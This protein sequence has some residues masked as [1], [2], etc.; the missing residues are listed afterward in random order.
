MDPDNLEVS[1]NHLLGTG[2]FAS[3]YKGRLKGNHISL[4]EGTRSTIAGSIPL[5][6]IHSSLKVHI[7]GRQGTVYDVAVKRLPIHADEAAKLDFQHEME[8]M[9]T[10][11]YHLHI[12]RYGSHFRYLYSSVS[13][14]VSLPKLSL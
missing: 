10:L 3:V 13:S 8:F 9:K 14:A 2:A 5:L 12:I 11:G 1:L 6:T 4:L 7:E